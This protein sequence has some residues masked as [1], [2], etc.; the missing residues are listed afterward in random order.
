MASPSR[1]IRN[2]T[3]PMVKVF[4]GSIQTAAFSY[5]GAHPDKTSEVVWAECLEQAK[6][7][8]SDITV[9]EIIE[10]FRLAGSGQWKD[11]ELDLAAYSGQF[12]VT[13]FCNV[14]NEYTRDRNKVKAAVDKVLGQWTEGHLEEVTR[15]KN[16]KARGQV[17][18]AFHKLKDDISNGG[19]VPE[20]DEIRLFWFD[21]LKDTGVLDLPR[22]TKVFLWDKS[23][24]L[25]KTDLSRPRDRYEAN[26]FKAIFKALEE[27]SVP[28]DYQ[29]KR[30]AKYKR[31]IIQAALKTPLTPSQ[32][33][34]DTKN[35][36][37]E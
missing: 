5:S 25:V 3:A 23:A 21:L 32:D 31:L 27:G 15:K 20:L 1:K 4:V 17:L 35:R 14:M 29:S 22:E 33:R 2:I 36:F 9:D 7:F 8:Y 18:E 19:R 6:R 12:T 30:K 10:A 24:E 13:T 16:E 26:T 28:D 11:R 37:S 34:T